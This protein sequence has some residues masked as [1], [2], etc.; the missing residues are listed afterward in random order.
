MAFGRFFM[1]STMRTI[2]E[3]LYGF[4]LLPE[5]SESHYSWI[6]NGLMTCSFSRFFNRTLGSLVTKTNFLA[7]KFVIVER[8][9][10]ALGGRLGSCYKHRSWSKTN[11][12]NCVRRYP[13]LQP[14]VSTPP[15]VAAVAAVAAS[16][17]YDQDQT[18][19]PNAKSWSRPPTDPM[20]RQLHAR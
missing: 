13:L 8:L 12:E 1:N 10:R 19:S 7:V 2:S 15:L 9:R 14:P 6:P 11:C 17:A 4:R 16:I 3:T 18:D 20:D 5:A